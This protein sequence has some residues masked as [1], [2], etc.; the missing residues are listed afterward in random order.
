M[1]MPD[2]DLRRAV[3]RALRGMEDY[4]PENL[5]E[6]V[7]HNLARSGRDTNED[8]LVGLLT[9]GAVNAAELTSFHIAL[10]RWDAEPGAEW[11]GDTSPSTRPRRDHVLQL[12]G[13]G[14]TAA[15]RIDQAHPPYLVTDISILD[16]DWDPWYTP[17]RRR[18]HRFYWSAYRRVLERSL[19]P[20][21]IGSLDA[22]T[23]NIVSRLADPAAEEPYQ[24]KGL[25]VG[26]VQSGKT[27]NFTGVVAK[28]IDAGYRLVIVLTGTVELLRAQTQRRLDMELLGEENILGGHDRNDPNAIAEVDYAGDGDLDWAANKFLRHDIDFGLTE[29]VPAIRRLTGKAVDYKRL[30]AGLD[31]LDFRSGNELRNPRKPVWHPEN[32]YNANVRIAVVKKNKAVL[33]K[34][35]QDLRNVHARLDEI[36]VLIID[37][38][39]DQASVNT[40]NP[41]KQT[42]EDTERTAINALIAQLLGELKRAQYIGY[43]ATPF[44]NVFVSPEDSEDIFPKDFII[45]LT[46]PDAYMGGRAFHD[47]DGLADQDVG[48]PAVSNE[49]A[50]VRDLRADDDATDEELRSALDAFVLSGAIKLWRAAQ[51]PAVAFRHHTMLVHESVRTVDHKELADRIRSIWARAAHTSPASKARLRELFERDYR[52]VSASRDWDAPMPDDFDELAPHIGSATDRIMTTGDPVII[53][54]GDKDRDYEQ[55]DFQTGD[56]WRIL[57]GGTKLSRGFTVEGLT[58]TYYRRRAL[59]ADSLMQMGRWF[60]YRR[61]YQDLVRLFISRNA[62]GP[63][64]KTYDLYEAFEAIVQDEEDFRAQLLKFAE[65]DDNGEPMIRP[66]QVPPLVFQQLPWLKPTA[67]N[68][69]YNAELDF[70]G[71]GGQLKDFPRQPARDRAGSI[72]EQHFAAIS[73]WLP[74]LTTATQEFEYLDPA[75]QRRGSFDARTVIVT[76]A[77]MVEVLRRFSW[78]DGFSFS[79]TLSMLERAAAEEKLVDWAVLVPYLSRATLRAIDGH[80]DLPI[81]RR[82]R[83][84]GTRGGFSGSSFRQRDAIEHIAG[85]LGVDGGSNASALHTPTRGAMLLTFAFDPAEGD[86]DPSRLSGTPA[87][88]DIAT[89]FSLAIP[90]LAAPRGRIGFKVRDFGHASEAIV[91][92]D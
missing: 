84:D 32:L 85:A 91:P 89:L 57:V 4:G 2:D 64:N 19:D 29:G 71:E 63:R 45:S 7:R 28:A 14:R 56:V 69:M 33:T 58:V 26:H 42:S 53:V 82:A 41:T 49:A 50:F 83:R 78:V 9:S 23:T 59:Q 40:V 90:R 6:D 13:F 35:V 65:L 76:A 8:E 21:A 72:N 92:A 22:I 61:G 24:A 46:P 47:L 5:L 3:V 55:V 18:D 12:L 62:S 11:A 68:K 79:P 10:S 87:T 1:T 37:D 17:D 48:N 60:G 66:S 77:E 20:D 86:R 74:R 34:L 38:E 73:G 25:V 88:A 36:P 30:A 52:V 31:A 70:V 15:E 51:N 27:A 67:R 81:L 75:S 54:N 16:P 43:T 44:A 39:A 80:A